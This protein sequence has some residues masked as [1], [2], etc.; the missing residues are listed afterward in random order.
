VSLAHLSLTEET[1]WTTWTQTPDLKVYLVAGHGHSTI[2]RLDGLET[3]QPFPAQTIEFTAELAQAS[4]NYAIEQEKLRQAK[5]RDEGLTILM[6]RGR[7]VPVMDGLE[8]DWIKAPWVTIDGKTEAAMQTGNDKLF[9]AMRSA[10]PGHERLT[11]NVADSKT[12]LFKGGGA[13]DLQLGTDPTAAPDRTKPVL[14]DLRLL[15]T[16]HQG[17]P[18]A[19]LYRPISDNTQRRETF[20]SPVQTVAIDE[21]LDASA[22][23]ELKEAHTAGRSF[24]EFSIPLKLL[25]LQPDA[26]KPLRG[27][28]G[29]IIGN[30]IET[31]AR[32]YWHNKRMTIVTDI[33]TEAS[34]YPQH[35]GTLRFEKAE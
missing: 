26:T 9:V 31:T 14:G 18:T 8:G 19:T 12:I 33:P 7:N 23:L 10:D 6:H 3:L 24:Y 34:L 15:V 25:R 13:I 20:T 17:K 11:R 29:V 35:W 32:A 5:S 27:D 2:T 28:I 30:A 16:Q 4:Q 22:D 21:I 1:F